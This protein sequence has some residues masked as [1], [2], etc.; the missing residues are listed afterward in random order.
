MTPSPSE[1]LATIAEELQTLNQRLAVFQDIAEEIMTEIQWA[2][3]NGDLVKPKCTR[4][5]A[6]VDMKE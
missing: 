1:S 6:P 3:Q 4:G 2:L 5:L